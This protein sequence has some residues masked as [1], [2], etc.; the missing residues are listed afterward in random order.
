VDEDEVLILVWVLGVFSLN[1]EGVA[2]N[3]CCLGKNCLFVW[4]CAIE[5][6]DKISVILNSVSPPTGSFHIFQEG[7]G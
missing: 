2:C 6:V 1:F 3:G 4:C 5:Q 7:S